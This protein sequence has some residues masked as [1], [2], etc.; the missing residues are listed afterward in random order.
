MAIEGGAMPAETAERTSGLAMRTP[1][2]V[3]S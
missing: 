2:A 1:S 3:V